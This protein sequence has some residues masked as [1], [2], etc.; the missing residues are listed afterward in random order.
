MWNCLARSRF[1]ILL[2]SMCLGYRR[3]RLNY[4]KWAP[5]LGLAVLAVIVALL[6][7]RLREI[8]FDD[9]LAQLRSLP[10]ASVLAAI[11]CSAGA[12]LLVGL[13]EGIALHRVSGQWRIAYA[14]R[15]TVISNPVARAVGVALVSGGALRY[16]FYAAIGLSARQVGTLVILMAMPYVLGVGWL[17]DV[18]LLMHPEE[19]SEALRVSTTTVLVLATLGIAKDVAWLA[20][21]KWRNTPIRIRQEQIRIPPL[22]HTLLQIAFGIAQ[23]LCNT[24]ILYLVMP[25][26]LDMSWPAFIAIYCIAFV[27]GQI[28]NVPAGLGVLEAVLL[29]MLP[30]VPPGKLLG[31]VVAYRAI[32]EVLPLLLGLALWAG[33][34]LTHRHGVVRRKKAVSDRALR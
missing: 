23:M 30:H 4:K 16:R 11:V 6:W 12:Y 10:L 1:K 27:A 32:F 18:S 8:E 13:Y 2:Y 33:Y 7:D 5:L 14:I 28:S 20:I 17:V 24:G 25:P 29:L 19:A 31:A 9:I 21:S 22:P 26:E 34:E 15:T 3:V